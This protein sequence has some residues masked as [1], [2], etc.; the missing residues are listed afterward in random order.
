MCRARTGGIR[1]G[2]DSS[3]DRPR[4]HP[5]VHVAFEDAEAYASGRARSCRPKP[6]GSSPHGAASRTRSSRWGDE[7]MPER[8][9]D[10]QHLAGRVPMAEPARRMVSSGP[11]RL[12]RSRRTATACTTWPATSG[13]GRPT[14][15]RSTARST[16]RAAR[17]TNPRGGDGTELRPANAGHSDPAQGH[18]GRLVSLRAELLS[19][20]SAGGA[21]GAGHRHVD[22][23]SRVPL[24][25]PTGRP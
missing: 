4:D 13:N 15:T 16:A 1:A 18:E 12:A 5:V 6:S 10:G 14:G 17:S 23:P 19:A 7:F 25:R 24:H 20:L 8:H 2:P 9:A 11:R 22:V 21:H 3:I